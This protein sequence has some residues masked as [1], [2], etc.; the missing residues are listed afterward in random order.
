MEEDYGIVLFGCYL[1][2]NFGMFR[3]VNVFCK[4]IGKCDVEIKIFGLI[5]VYII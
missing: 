5:L 2:V 4:K 3:L 1:F